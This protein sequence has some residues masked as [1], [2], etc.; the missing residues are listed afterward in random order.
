M[1][2][3]TITVAAVALACMLVGCGPQ[4]KP[5]ARR[6]D[7]AVA[8][9]AK[10][11]G[12]TEFAV[13]PKLVRRDVYTDIVFELKTPADVTVAVLSKDGR[14]VRHIGCGVLGE[15]APEPFRK[16]SLTQKLTWDGRDD[17][18][19]PAPPECRIMVGAG[20]RVVFDRHIEWGK[21]EEVKGKEGGCLAI[22]RKRE[23][24]YV[25]GP[26]VPGFFRAYGRTGRVHQM[27]KISHNIWGGA[28]PT[29]ETLAAARVTD[30]ALDMDGEL[31]VRIL[32]GGKSVVRRYD[33]GGISILFGNKREIELSLASPGS[34]S[35][36]LA[37]DGNGDVYARSV[38]SGGKGRRGTVRDVMEVFGSYGRPRKTDKG[39]SVILAARADGFGREAA[40]DVKRSGVKVRDRAG[41]L[42]ASFGSRG[43]GSKEPYFQPSAAAI[44]DEAVY[45]LNAANGRVVRGKITFAR[46]AELPVR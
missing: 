24:L 15:N 34:R 35:N 18:G 36:G 46:R 3:C 44:S 23:E 14:V 28:P 41:N 37:V 11:S 1:R 43:E 25:A 19:K 26:S 45:V 5:G 33:R 27:E 2:R 13:S 17:R 10:V 31:Y 9:R 30:I 16:G 39:F 32:K 4:K 22:D 7:G 21:P 12:K 42:I 20:T 8:G 40:P 29:A 6:G 38:V